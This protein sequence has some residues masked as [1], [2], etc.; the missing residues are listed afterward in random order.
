M[1]EGDES[2]PLAPSLSK[3]G[4]VFLHSTLSSAIAGAQSR[5]AAVAL[6]ATWTGLDYL[7]SS[8]AL[9]PGVARAIAIN[10]RR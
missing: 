2:A 1:A 10:V 5:S 7:S 8:R 3:P 6:V 4:G 9:T